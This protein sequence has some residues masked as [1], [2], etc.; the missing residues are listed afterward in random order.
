MD[1]KFSGSEDPELVCPTTR[2]HYEKYRKM[3]L[4]N[5]RDLPNLSGKGKLTELFKEDHLL[6]NIPLVEFDRLYKSW[7]TK[8]GPKSL[9]EN[10]CMYKHYIIYFVIGAKPLFTD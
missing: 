1:N 4:D 8:T 3:V 2:A 5:Y 9:A 7:A 10:V 6:N